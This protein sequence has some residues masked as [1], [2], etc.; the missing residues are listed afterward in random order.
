MEKRLNKRFTQTIIQVT[1]K[2]NVLL[3]LSAPAFCQ[4]QKQLLRAPEDLAFVSERYQ[5]QPREPLR[6]GSGSD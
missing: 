4:S 1:F 5:F 6:Q 2:P 3:T